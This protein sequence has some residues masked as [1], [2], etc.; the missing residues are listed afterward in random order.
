MKMSG[1]TILITGGGSG[2]GQQLAYRFHEL[3]NKVIVAG[4][5][6]EALEETIAGREGM[7]AAV[8]DVESPEAIKAFA[9]QVKAEHPDLNV[10]INNA[11]IMRTEDVAA[12]RDLGDAE[13][14]IVTNL[15]GP[16]RLID[17][18]VEHL[19]AQ[20]DAAIVNVTSGLAFVPLPHTPT[21]SATKAAMH[22]YSVAMR[23]QLEG[24][25]EVI[26]LIPPAVQTDLT[27]G[28]ATREGYLPLKDFIDEVMDLFQQQPTP[29]EI[30]VKRVDFL[31]NAEAEGR[32][33][34]ALAALSA[35]G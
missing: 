4:R 33:E 10:L 14:T 18:F 28:Q 21:Y 16:I 19:A 6:R 25:V 32:F 1:N 15:L 20:S 8:L 29:Q 7:S 11:G 31:R 23:V 2:I 13:A 12:A 26:E 17:A 35:H 5:R 24:K 34:Q 27:P 3:G 22:S 9:E 30:R